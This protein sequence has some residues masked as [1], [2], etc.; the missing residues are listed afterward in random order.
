MKT[1]YPLKK[2]SN[3]GFFERNLSIFTPFYNPLS[4][5]CGERAASENRAKA[6]RPRLK[7]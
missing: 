7:W 1:S 5:G 2:A 6:N 4:F 3:Y